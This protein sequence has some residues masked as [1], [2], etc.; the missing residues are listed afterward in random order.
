MKTTFGKRSAFP[1]TQV[2]D[3]DAMKIVEIKQMM[4]TNGWKIL[5][6]Y[7]QTLRLLLEERIKADVETRPGRD[8]SP[9]NAA[10]LAGFDYFLNH[11]TRIIN[12]LEIQ[13][14]AKNED[15]DGSDEFG[16]D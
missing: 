14:E 15:G 4:Q 10:K 12:Q 6:G 5:E 8:R 16:R 2:E 1:T 11:P 13:R 9:I 3:E 7:Y